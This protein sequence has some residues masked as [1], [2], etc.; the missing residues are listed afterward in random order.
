MDEVE[1]GMSWK[2]VEVD[3]EC[4]YNDLSVLNQNL[5]FQIKKKI[6][7]ITKVSLTKI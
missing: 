4:T 7:I 2:R 5:F 6:A 1:V 3:R